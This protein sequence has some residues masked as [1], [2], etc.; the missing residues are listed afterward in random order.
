MVSSKL[1]DWPGLLYYILTENRRSWVR[2]KEF[3][4]QRLFV[5]RA[6]ARETLYQFLVSE[7]PTQ[8]EELG[9]TAVKVG[10]SG[11]S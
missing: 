6:V 1:M 8:R 3:A 4:K 5:V 11:L 10:S 7:S 2:N 9:E